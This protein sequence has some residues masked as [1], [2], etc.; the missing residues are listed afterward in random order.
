VFL[1]GASEWL[2]ESS[3]PHQ[4]DD[5]YL[6][7]W[8]HFITCVLENYVPLVTGEDGLRVLE[9]IEAAR[10]SAVSAGQVQVART[11]QTFE[12]KS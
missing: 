10:F 6:T 1:A 11:T 5:S 3:H 8:Q 9:I 7:E 2:Q 12:A 4:R